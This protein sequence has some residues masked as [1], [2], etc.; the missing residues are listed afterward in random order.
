MGKINCC[1][2][3]MQIKRDR[4]HLSHLTFWTDGATKEASFYV[5]EP[6]IVLFKS[7]CLKNKG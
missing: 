2:T 3:I 7:H 6:V 4:M 5:V 1:C